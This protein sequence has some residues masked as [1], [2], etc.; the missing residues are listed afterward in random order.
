MYLPLFNALPS[1]QSSS[2]RSPLQAFSGAGRLFGSCGKAVP[3]VRVAIKKGRAS[4]VGS[5][6]MD[7]GQWE[8]DGS[9]GVC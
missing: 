7:R 6:M 5:F 2:V 3:E 1:H 9:P 8:F 4:V